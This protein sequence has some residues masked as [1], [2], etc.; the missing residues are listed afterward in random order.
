MLKRLVAARRP[1]EA[2][3]AIAEELEVERTLTARDPNDLPE[4]GLL[5]FAR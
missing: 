1:A 2:A 5:V 4:A 3:G